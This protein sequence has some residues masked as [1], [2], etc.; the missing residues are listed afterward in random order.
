M[1]PILAGIVPFGLA[2]GVAAA[3]S[4]VGR[5]AGWATSWTIYA[6]SAQ[7]AAI[8][9]LDAH[10]APLVVLATV[11]AVNARLLLYG[12]AIAPHWREA[13]RWWRLLAAYLLVDPTF[14]VAADRY[15]CP[16]TPEEKRRFYL[17]AALTL[18]LGWQLATAAGAVVGTSAPGASTLEMVVPL[19][20][21]GLL[22]AP[23]RST[24]G[25]VAAAVGGATAVAS[26][27]L[28]MGT[29][30]IVAAIAGMLAGAAAEGRDR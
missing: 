22:V 8:E 11:V 20:L 26:Q 29:G 18:W 3:G 23:T 13:P 2:V 9:L 12:A 16:A 27:A 6:G 25:R 17:G 30:V 19:T 14:V 1:L 7:L 10:A 28:P 15:R 5:V 4:S 21:V 24:A